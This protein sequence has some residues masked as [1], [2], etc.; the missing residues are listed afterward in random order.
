M[1]VLLVEI[2]G[3]EIDNFRQKKKILLKSFVTI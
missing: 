1:L 2:S 3:S